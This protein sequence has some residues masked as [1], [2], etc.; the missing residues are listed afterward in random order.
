MRYR[1]PPGGGPPDQRALDAPKRER[2]PSGLH[3]L[4]AVGGTARSGAQ[5][6]VSDVMS[7][8]VRTVPH[9]ARASDAEQLMHGE[10]EIQHLVV[11]DET[12]R[13]VGVVSDRDLR[14]AEP[15]MLLVRDAAH[16]E[17]AL[18]LLKVA[19]VMTG[20]PYSVHPTANLRSALL[21]MRRHKVGCLPVVDD[22]HK[23]VGIITGFDVIKIALRLLP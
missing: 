23:P 5:I 15:S 14:A 10:R 22:A 12:G 9:D 16:R 13:V 19:S 11:V 1:D 21:L 3:N 17:R 2:E 7:T 18:A 20:N 8:P 6:L 4:D